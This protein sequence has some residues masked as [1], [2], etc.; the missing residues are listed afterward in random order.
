M[1]LMNGGFPP[2]K[3]MVPAYNPIQGIVSLTLMRP[4]IIRPHSIL[5]PIVMVS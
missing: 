1:G 4:L 5:D 3:H 2:K